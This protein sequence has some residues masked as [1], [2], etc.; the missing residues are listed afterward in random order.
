M[1]KLI[2]IAGKMSNIAY[3]IVK[4]A[5]IAVSVQDIATDPAATRIGCQTHHAST[6][7]NGLVK[8][9]KLCRYKAGRMWMY[10]LPPVKGEPVIKSVE[11]P[12]ETPAVV[13]VAIAGLQ[14]QVNK[15]TKRLSLMYEGLQIEISVVG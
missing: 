13:P 5:G 9:G 4:K 11:L 10:E 1:A 14:I 8:A 2:L 15:T 12:Q 3:E 6:A 7:L